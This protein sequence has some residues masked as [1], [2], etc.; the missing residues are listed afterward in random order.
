MSLTGSGRAGRS[1]PRHGQRHHAEGDD[2]DGEDQDGHVAGQATPPENVDSMTEYTTRDGAIG[3][4]TAEI[5]PGA[6]EKRVLAG[7][8]GVGNLIT[9]I[10]SQSG[11][12]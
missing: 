8:D 1:K 6:S 7:L 11:A 9:R 12:A 10:C 5:V 3:H 4:T 2:Q